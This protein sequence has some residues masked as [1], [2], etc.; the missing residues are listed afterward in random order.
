MFTAEEV[1]QLFAAD[2]RPQ[3]SWAYRQ[4]PPIDALVAV[5][6]NTIVGFLALRELTTGDAEVTHLYVEPSHHRRG[7]GSA[8]WN[9]GTAILRDRG[10]PSV[11][12]WTFKR[13]SAVEFY[14]SLGCVLAD[15]A[16]WTGGGHRERT[17]E[18]VLGL[19]ENC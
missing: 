5:I 8:L 2:Q 14:G 7:I 16:V 3:L 1:E 11:H 4:G 15:E 17:L 13:G 9:A 6:D 18:F 19:R 12:V 10:V